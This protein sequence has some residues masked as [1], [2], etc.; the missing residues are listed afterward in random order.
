MAGGKP[1]GA[2]PAQAQ[3]TQ[4]QATQTPPVRAE[5]DALSAGER[6]AQP[7]AQPP[8]RS[9]EAAL[10]AARARV[11]QNPMPA[12]TGQ[13]VTVADAEKVLAARQD[14]AR[15]EAMRRVQSA[16]PAVSTPLANP[17]RPSVQRTDPPVDTP[18]IRDAEPSDFEKLLEAEL[19]ANGVFAGQPPQVRSDREVN[20]APGAGVVP[21]VRVTPPITGATADVTSEEE[22]ARLLGEIAVNRKP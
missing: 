11:L 19:D 13:P 12:V 22:V 1:A 5:S 18:R 17:A 7:L 10:D 2:M 3:S 6:R 14:A 8:V 21:P 4:F 15:L 16:Q 20:A 9:A